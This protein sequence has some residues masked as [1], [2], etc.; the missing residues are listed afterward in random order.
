RRC[1]PALHRFEILELEH[2]EPLRV[3]VALEH[4]EL[5]AAGD[6]AP[7]AGRDRA[8]RRGLVLLVLLGVVD[9][10]LDD[11]IR[12]HARDFTLKGMAET[13]TA[14]PEETEA[15]AA[16]LAARLV[17]GDL[18]TVAGELGAGK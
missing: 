7:A 9:V 1:V 18:V 12:R 16:G 14:S 8:G 17:E 2:D 11:H 15:L 6:E 3:P 10:R 4:G 13:E 5:A